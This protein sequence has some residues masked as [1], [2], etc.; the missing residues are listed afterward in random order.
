LVKN[1][2]VFP[3]FYDKVTKRLRY[4]EIKLFL[5]Q[6]LNKK[7]NDIKRNLLQVLAY[8]LETAHKNTIINLK[9]DHEKIH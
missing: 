7:I 3:F 9:P 5:I 8:N 6:V 4:F 1:L 2:R